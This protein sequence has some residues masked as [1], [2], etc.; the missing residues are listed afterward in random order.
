MYYNLCTSVMANAVKIGF[1]AGT[2]APDRREEYLEKALRPASLVN[3]VMS[4]TGPLSPLMDAS[5]ILGDTFM[6]DTWNEVAGGRYGFRGK[7]LTAA[8]P[9]LDFI[10]KAYKGVS[11]MS[12]ATFTDRELSPADWRSLYSIMPFSN[13][14]V[15]DALNNGLITPNLFEE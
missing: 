12:T 13:Q 5:N 11:G 2:M 7:G 6:G 14:Y 10:N 1:A 3:Q 15:F 9:G 4:Y 8:V